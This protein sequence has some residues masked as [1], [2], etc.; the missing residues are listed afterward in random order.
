MKIT[1]PNDEDLSSLTLNIKGVDNK[2]I[3]DFQ[4]E[5]KSE[6]KRTYIIDSD[7]QLLF[8]Y[9]AKGKY[10]IRITEDVNRNGIVDTGNLLKHIQ[11]EKVRYFK[12]D[13]EDLIEIP[14]RSEIIQDLDLRTM[15]K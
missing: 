3:V 2:Y 15:F 4:N 6:I 12:I 8:P 5:S 11:P 1:L 9:L 10:A 13:D 7:C 14:E